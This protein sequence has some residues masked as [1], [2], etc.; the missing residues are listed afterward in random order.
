[1]FRCL[2]WTNWYIRSKRHLFK[3]L[4]DRLMTT[5]SAAGWAAL[6]AKT[7]AIF[8]TSGQRRRAS[9]DRRRGQGFGSVS[10]STEN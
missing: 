4:R 9:T 7:I 10:I 3:Q 8:L 1:M 5:G 2:H 6:G